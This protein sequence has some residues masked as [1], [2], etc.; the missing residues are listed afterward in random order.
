M[1]FTTQYQERF[2]EI[3]LKKLACMPLRDENILCLVFRC[4][5]ETIAKWKTEN[6]SFK[7]AIEYG[8]ISGEY[9]FRELL[10]TLSLLPGK[11]VNNNILNLLSANVYGIKPDSEISITV[12]ADSLDPET[13]MKRKGIPIPEIDTED[14]EG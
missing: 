13:I 3:A 6:E 5:K 12:G 9:K 14:L 1:Q 8:L 7:Q 2:A 11:Q 4:T 10:F